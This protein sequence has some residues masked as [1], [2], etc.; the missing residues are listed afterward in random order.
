MALYPLIEFVRR[1]A[2]APDAVTAVANLQ[3]MTDELGPAKPAADVLRHLEELAFPAAR[4][5][6]QGRKY[7]PVTPD[8]RRKLRDL[9]LALVLHVE[10]DLPLMVVVEDA[11]WLDPSSLELVDRM[12]AGDQ[13]KARDAQH[14]EPQ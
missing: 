10:Q 6:A 4:N 9:L 8:T 14:H 11:H 1:A 2:A 12:I 7:P 13:W 5:E 3:R